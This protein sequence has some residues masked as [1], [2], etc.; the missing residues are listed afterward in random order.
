MSETSASLLE[1]LQQRP[2]PAS[3]QRLVDLYTP[4]LHGWL[5]RYSLQQADADDVV[6]DVLGVVVRELPGFHHNQ[7]RGA[8]RSWLRSILVNRLRNFWRN[9]QTHAA[10]MGSGDKLQMLDQLEDSASG[11]SKLWDQEHDRHVVHRLLES[12]EPDFSDS[13]W[14]AFRKVVLEGKEEAIAAKESGIS[15][16]AVFIAKSRVLNRL[17]QEGRGLIG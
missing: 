1:R 11:V 4:L 8:F 13:T 15:L 16:N 3:W 12:V 17:R 10:V 14:Q 6:Q 7:H 9:R 2:D 5:R